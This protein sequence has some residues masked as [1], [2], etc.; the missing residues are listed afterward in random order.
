VTK[1]NFLKLG[2]G[3]GL[4]FGFKDNWVILFL[5]N[6]S[7]MRI[8]KFHSPHWLNTIGFLTFLF[9]FGLYAYTMS[10]TV[11]FWDCGEFIACANH[12]GVGHAPGAPLYLLLARVFA[13]FASPEKV[14]FSINLVSVCASALTI[15]VLY[16]SIYLLIHKVDAAAPKTMSIA[17][18]LIGALT[19][20]VTDTFWSSAVESEVYALS[21][22]FTALT[23]WATL[24]WDHQYPSVD[25][26]RW[27]L[28]VVFL[29][30]LS[31]GVHL[32][33]LLLI[34][35]ISVV[36][37]IRIKGFSVLSLIIGFAVG[38]LLLFV[39]WFMMIE[40]G[41]YIAQR[42]ELFLVNHFGA[43]Q[44]S[45]LVGFVVL[46]LL[47]IFVMIFVS[48]E[49]PVIRFLFSSLLLFFIGYSSYATILIRSNVKPF[50]N[51][52]EPK[53]CFMLEAYMNRE[54]YGVRP[55]VKGPWFGAKPISYQLNTGYRFN[56]DGKYE[57]YEKGEQAIY[58]D[59][60]LLYFSRMYNADYQS[61]EGYEFWSGI[62]NAEKPA[63]CDELKYFAKYQLGHMYFRYFMWNFS[64]RQNH[65][66]G[67]G[68]FLQGNFLTGLWFV[69]SYFLGSRTNL[70]AK[71]LLS[72]SR[73]VY[74]L[75]PLVFGLFGFGFLLGAHKNILSILGLLFIM[76]GPLIVLY[77]NQPPFEPRERDYIFMGSF[78]A[79]G[80]FIAFGIFAVLK[81]FK[82]YY[83]L[84]LTPYLLML[85]LFIA[86]PGL[87]MFT[88]FDDHNR[89]SRTLARD[90]A[91]SY[92]NS[93]EPNAILVTYGDNDTY[94]LWYVQSV[95]G[96]RPDVRVI[97]GGLLSV[98]WY[99][100]QQTYSNGLSKP[101]R[102]T[103][104]I[105]RYQKGGLDYVMVNTANKHPQLITMA[106]QDLGNVKEDSK[107]VALGDKQLDYL[108]TSCFVL[109]NDSTMTIELN[110]RYYM[111]GE[112]ALVD[113]IV[114]NCHDRPVY[115]TNVTPV[116]EVPGFG[117]YFKQ[118]GL[119][120]ELVLNGKDLGLTGQ[121]KIFM[122]DIHL[123]IYNQSWLDATCINVLKSSGIRESCMSLAKQLI[124]N[125]Q[126]NEAQEVMLKYNRIFP[127]GEYDESKQALEWIDLLF[128][129]QLF[130][131]ALLQLNY[132]IEI[133]SQNYFFYQSS[134]EY[135]GVG[136][137]KYAQE[138]AETLQRL[139][140]M[141][142]KYKD[143][144]S[145]KK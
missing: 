104:P 15:S 96:I 117:K 57:L 29:L 46:F 59:E 118:R 12:L 144:L 133:T 94:P 39:V 49:K 106:L 129:T 82:K 47:F 127:L 85:L 75:I 81:S 140:E 121:A 111:K 72:A 35:V 43:P 53:D 21:L 50:L 33:N 119:L 102:F 4:C 31:V 138:E 89:H 103:I 101:V 112:L 108:S 91:V 98:D 87:L 143:P 20:A 7:I 84:G 24:K 95:E 61:I 73:N 30:G 14:A 18:S 17:A 10:P 55:L 88:N 126:I 125:D 26:F 51:L 136:M 22:C 6:H 41:L 124:K 97:N 42:M 71:E 28:L 25:A 107:I 16:N 52:N 113:L 67:Y 54:Q 37:Y 92:L 68:D 70:N 100:R 77:L 109:H 56:K 83:S 93:C 110:K 69:D 145:V 131:E 5:K 76:M 128:K 27:L 79:F 32:L 19:F 3:F 9:S 80:F 40:N 74:Y 132:Y 11:N 63:F 134:V 90:M 44:H 120:K 36:V 65:Y 64:G 122:K 48:K 99:I 58:D 137:N 142:H 8:F 60:D 78:Y 114:S 13:V 45:G 1:N 34:P 135:L 66:Q 116:S 130:N 123:P 2:F 38:V 62:Q 141:A 23:F 139:N 115:V 86:L 105:E